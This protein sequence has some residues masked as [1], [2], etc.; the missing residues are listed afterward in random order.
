MVLRDQGP[1]YVSKV[2]A[3]ACRTLGLRHIRTRS[4]TPRTNGKAE[5]FIQ[6]L[7]EGWAYV[8][9]YNTSTARLAAGM[10]NPLGKH[11]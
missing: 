2:F 7:L 9:P 11:T 4:C 10:N 5:R 1:A 6:T 3:K 8:M